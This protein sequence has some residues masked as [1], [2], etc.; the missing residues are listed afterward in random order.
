MYLDFFDIILVFVDHP[1]Q[2]ARIVQMSSGEIVELNCSVRANPKA[3]INWYKKTKRGDK[4]LKNRNNDP[5]VWKLTRATVNKE[6][7]CI[8]KNDIGS[9]NRTFSVRVSGKFVCD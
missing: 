8:V 3:T 6:Y 2:T 1:N 7:V 9:R 4:Q 5:F